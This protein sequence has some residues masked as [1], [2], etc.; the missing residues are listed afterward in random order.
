MLLRGH[1]IEAR[2]YAEDP[3]SYL[4]AIG[5]LA[6]LELP[7]GP[8]V[9]IDAGV[10]RGDEIT[11]HYD[12]LIAKLIV[13]GESR[14]AAVARMGRALDEVALL[15]LTTNL[16][17]LRAVV[18][19]PAYAAGDT[20]TGFL[21]DH[22]LMEAGSP[23][24]PPEVLAAA[25]LWELDQGTTSSDPFATHWRIAGN[26]VLVRLM[27]AAREYHLLA[28]RYDTQWEVAVADVIARVGLMRRE[29][30][31]L[32]LDLGGGTARFW[33]ARAEDGALLVA[34]RG[35]TYRLTQGGA[36][37][38]DSAARAHSSRGAANLMAP[39]PGTLVRLLVSEGEQVHEGQALMVL[40][41]MK[42]EHTVVAPYAGIVRCL[43]YHQGSGVTSGARLVEID[44]L[45]SL[46]G[47]GAIA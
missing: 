13:F 41:A 22:S 32:I 2:L 30:G 11:V 25:A 4:P 21:G 15:G 33:L 34:W 5:R 16:P 44:P 14:Q 12:P 31:E 27:S 1:A 20:H 24:V 43:A 38:A 17:L 26:G 23:E 7:S 19:H 29:S 28:H 6:L 35:S 42:M 47:R 46:P 18:A 39:M 40:E 45:D 37:S 8:G 3:V 10:V 9:R 36:L